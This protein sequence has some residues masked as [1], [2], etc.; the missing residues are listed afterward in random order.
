MASLAVPYGVDPSQT[1]EEIRADAIKI[2]KNALL[3]AIYASVY[4]RLLAEVPPARF[5]RLLELGSGGGFF[6]EAA[7]HAITSEFVAVPGIDRV[8]DATRLSESF[9]DSSLDAIAAFNVFHHLADPSAFLRGVSTVLCRGGRLALVEPWFTP[10]GQWF[11]R[12]LHHEP[13]LLDPEEWRTV[14]Q[15][16]LAGANSRLPTS[17]FRDSDVRFGKEFPRLAILKREPIHKWLYLLSGGLRLNTHV[18]D[19]LAE[20]LVRL[21]EQVLLGDAQLGLFAVIVIERVDGLQEP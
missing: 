7:P 4:R 17:V 10:V 21:D 2:R 8:V 3:R 6:K 16:R 5:P 18:P 20:R 15:G 11:Y 13:Y 12:L 14:G 1:A 9:G 19:F